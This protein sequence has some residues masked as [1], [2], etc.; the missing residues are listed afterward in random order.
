[1]GL[2]G[3]KSCSATIWVRLQSRLPRDSK[4]HRLGVKPFEKGGK[5]SLTLKRMLSVMLPR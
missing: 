1:V 5:N 4:S 3:R 2:E